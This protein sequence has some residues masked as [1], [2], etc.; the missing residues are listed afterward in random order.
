MMKYL[1]AILLPLQTFCC[2]DEFYWMEPWYGE[3]AFILKDDEGHLLLDFNDHLYTI[4]EI[5]HSDECFCKYSGFTS[6]DF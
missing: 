3:F 2:D 6:S 1:L 4:K 5:E